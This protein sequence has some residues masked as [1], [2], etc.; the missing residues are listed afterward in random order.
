MRVATF[1]CKHAHRQFVGPWHGYKRG[2]NG[3]L[4]LLWRPLLLLRSCLCPSHGIDPHMGRQCLGQADCWHI[5]FDGGS[6]T[7]FYTQNMFHVRGFPNV[8][9][10]L[11][12]GRRTHTE[13][14]RNNKQTNEQA[15]NGQTNKH[16]SE[17]A[18]YKLQPNKQQPNERMGNK[19]LN[20]EQGTSEQTNSRASEPTNN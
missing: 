19:L 15:T 14:R 12:L 20:N 1:K 18:T 10:W 16:T 5:G 2:K 13:T 9:A 3:H 7:L 4:G 6:Y 11:T 8:S 17:Q